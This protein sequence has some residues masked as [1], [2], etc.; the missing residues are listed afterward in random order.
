MKTSQYRPDIDGLRALSV[1]I[2]LFYHLQILTF[3]GGFVG[4]DVFFVISGFLITG[5]IM[6]DLENKRFS[7]R[8]FYRRRIARIVPALLVTIVVSLSAATLLLMP[9]ALV[10][11]AKQGISALFSLSN[12]FFL[13]DSNY[14]G[15]LT[16]SFFLLHTWSLGVEEQFYLAYPLFLLILFR[17]FHRSGLFWGIFFLLIIGAIGNIFVLR[18]DPAMAFYFGPLRFYEFAIG[19]IGSFFFAR[20]SR[21]HA[22]RGA[23]S[24]VSCLGL[25]L[26][27]YSATTFSFYTT[28]PG[29][30]ALVPTVGALLVIMSGNSLAASRLLANPP[31]VWLGKIS[32][33][34]YLVHWP[35]IVMYRYC[36]GPNLQAFDRVI[37]VL[38]SLLLA[39]ILN[40]A[41]EQRFRL[42]RDDQNTLTGLPWIKVLWTLVITS[43]LFTSLAITLI[44]TRG[45]P[46]RFPE[47]LN[48]IVSKSI[49]ATAREKRLFLESNCQPQNDT[50]CGKRDPHGKNIMLLSDSLGLDIYRSLLSGFPDISVKVAYAMGCA[51]V[52]NP[53]IGRSIHFADC[54]NFNRRRLDAA[55]A[56]PSGDIVLLAMDFNSWRADYVLETAKRLVENGKRVYVL[57][58]TRFLRGKSPQQIAIDQHRFSL[59]PNYVDRFL[60]PRPFG[61]EE[62]YGEKFDAIGATYIATK[63]FFKPDTQYRLFTQ[64]NDELLSY[65]GIHF[66]KKGAIEFG[67]YLARHYHF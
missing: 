67:K 13:S 23:R 19:G 27:L 63:G 60:A 35:L 2:I 65:D 28:F 21:L 32:Y 52:F 11:T 36:L 16:K 59:A 17:I 61:L 12:I 48:H 30:N 57:G 37:L 33:S 18:A 55:L 10:H 49:P 8:T 22:P 53:N 1:V 54:P 41:V 46:E 14:W 4:V 51:P 45:L 43:A 25:T 42:S 50:F 66:S 6:D 31:M 5:I 24:L 29:L 62:E 15:A 9:E 3:S 26:I 34:L 64:E 47:D 38:L 7:L 44:A 20:V 56:A 40:S 58:E 39:I